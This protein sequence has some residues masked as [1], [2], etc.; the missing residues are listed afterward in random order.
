VPNPWQHL[1]VQAGSCRLKLPRC[2]TDVDD[3]GIHDWPPMTGRWNAI[4]FFV[5]DDVGLRHQV[6]RRQRQLPN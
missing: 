4:V 5:S 6:E 3:N 1:I 2:D